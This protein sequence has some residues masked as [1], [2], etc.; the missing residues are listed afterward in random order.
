MNKLIKK[1]GL[2]V[3][4]IICV[5]MFYH[6]DGNQYLN[7]ENLKSHH[8]E[9]F[10][11]YQQNPLRFTLIYF[12]LYVGLVA[13]SF[14]GATVLS[15]A[16]GYIFGFIKGLLIIN[17]ASTIGACIAFL[18]ARF[19]FKDYLQRKFHHTFQKINQGMDR[20]GNQYLLTLRLIPVFPFFLINI[21]MGLTNISLL[22]FFVVSL[23]GMLP[24]TA[25]YVWAGTTLQNINSV[26]D[27]F[28]AKLITIFFLVGLIPVLQSRIL[29]YLKQIKN[30]S[31]F[32]TPKNYDYNL[33]VIGGGAAGLVNAYIATNL[34]AKVLLVE[35]DKMGGECL[36]Y[37]CVPSKALISL[38]KTKKYSKANFYDLKNEIAKIIESIAPHD[39]VD[40]YKEMGVEC[41]KG[42]ASLISPFE[43][44][45]NGTN[46]TGRKIIIATG[47]KPNYPNI[48]GLDVNKVFDYESIWKIESL[49]EKLVIIG[50]GAIGCELALAFSNLGTKVTIIE[51]NEVLGTEDRDVA[52]LVMKGLIGNK[53]DICE[54][55]DLLTINHDKCS[56]TFRN[57]NEVSEVLFDVLL[58]AC[59]K[60]GNTDSI[61]TTL[62]LDLDSKKFILVNEYLETLKYRNIYACGDVNGLKQLTN[63][64]AHQAW[65]TS[66]NAL[67]GNWKKFSIEHDY[68]PH[69]VF[70]EPEIARVG[71][72]EL[73]ALRN[74]LE[75]DLY[76]FDSSDLDRNLIERKKLGMIKVLT[77]KNT[78][79]ILGVTIVGEAASEIIAEYVLAMKYKLGLSKVLAT[80]H[81]YPSFS[82]QN[83]YVAGVWKKRSVP[84]VIL[85]VLKKYHQLVR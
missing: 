72:N 55:S 39:S 29:I 26:S 71:V 20:E 12:V 77:I 17:W 28:T 25:V 79:Q 15:L 76:H 64:A 58:I 22:R 59:G 11:F 23:I 4:I 42:K 54:K 18:L 10:T 14:P 62:N 19:F 24:G 66:V 61:S 82:E 51:Q 84:E 30:Y 31:Q 83:K 74:N 47:A 70:V 41:V 1:V 50:G 48:K 21:L 43:V 45:I 68:I 67:F 7:F 53:I 65:Y 85:K 6:L 78:D 33:I 13:L 38:S 56:I 57:K 37:G 63:A 52:S 5:I 2:L 46:Y 34:K 75:Y 49:P 16:G 40:R 69:A 81:I 3:L 32:K 8:Q 27:I 60:I 35:E 73:D 36:N 44:Q 80:S 9:L